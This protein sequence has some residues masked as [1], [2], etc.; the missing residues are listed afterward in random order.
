MK[1]IFRPILREL[2]EI[3]K[4]VGARCKMWD[5]PYRNQEW[6]GELWLNDPSS[7][8]RSDNPFASNGAPPRPAG[9]MPVGGFGLIRRYRR[10]P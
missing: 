1:L 8:R 10:L 4:G 7:N 3:D 2:G 6:W 9:R 5:A